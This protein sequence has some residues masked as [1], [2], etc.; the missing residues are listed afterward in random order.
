MKQVFLNA[1]AGGGSINESEMSTETLN[2]AFKNLIDQVRIYFDFSLEYI[3]Q[4]LTI[5]CTEI[6]ARK[7]NYVFIY[8]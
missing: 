2:G 6:L 3:P 1:N 8:L 4:N 5:F 7:V